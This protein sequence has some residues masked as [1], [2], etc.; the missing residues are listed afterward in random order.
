M[1][2]FPA[3]FLP[4]LAASVLAAFAF[5]SPARAADRLLVYA[6]SAAR[7]PIEEAVALFERKTGVRVDVAFGGSGYVLSQLKLARRGD[8][9]FPGSSDYME[10]AKREGDVFPETERIVVYLVPAINVRKGNPK[11]IRTLEDLARPGVKVAI[12]NPEGVCVGAYAVEI[13]EKRFSPAGKEMFRKNVL[14]YMESCERTATA[15]SLQQVDAVIGWSVFGHWDP[16]RI[17]T[18]PLPA[19]EIPRIG[20]IPVAVSRHTKRRA[21]AER[22]IDFLFSPEGR[23][24]FSRHAYFT[25]PAEAFAWIGA[26]RPVGGEYAVPPYWFDK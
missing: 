23:E 13:V 14:N 9:Y 17:E 5:P 26:K 25:T 21:L 15:L 18:V 8:V 11:R 4:V 12:G 16:E 19:D 22:F 10:K 20:Y 24:V 2:G 1:R 3:G 7:P 6:G